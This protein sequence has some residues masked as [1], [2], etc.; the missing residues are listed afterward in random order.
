MV[1]TGVKEAETLRVSRPR[2]VDGRGGGGE[3]QEP[4][5]PP[6]PR[7]G[8]HQVDGGAFCQRGKIEEEHAWG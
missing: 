6:T 5:R 2:E 8:A 4:K 1:W 7:L 3:N